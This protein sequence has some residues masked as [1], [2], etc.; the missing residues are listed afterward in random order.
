MV[1]I[2]KDVNTYHFMNH[3]VEKLAE[4]DVSIWDAYPQLSRCQEQVSYLAAL[5]SSLTLRSHRKIVKEAVPFLA[6]RNLNDEAT[7]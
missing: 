3:I 6:W 2:N 7:V 4:R 1:P 5:Y